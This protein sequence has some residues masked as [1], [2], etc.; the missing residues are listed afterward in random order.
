MVTK[1]SMVT[2]TRKKV[3]KMVIIPS[4]MTKHHFNHVVEKN[5]AADVFSTA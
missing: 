1:P 5:E 4:M 3:K 2:K